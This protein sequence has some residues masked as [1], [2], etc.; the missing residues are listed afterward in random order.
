MV[1]E[2]TVMAQLGDRRVCIRRM[3]NESHT[4]SKH[5]DDH[6]LRVITHS[7]LVRAY[8][9]LLASDSGMVL[10]TAS[11]SGMVL[12]TSMTQGDEEHGGLRATRLLVPISHFWDISKDISKEPWPWFITYSPPYR[13]I[14]PRIDI[15]LTNT[16]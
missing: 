8:R 3:K 1:P 12:T 16:Q 15:K 5:P 4:S 9:E 14:R 11:D 13:K 7:S 2:A 6:D 10:I